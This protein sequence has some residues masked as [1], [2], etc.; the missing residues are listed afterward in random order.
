MIG[1]FSRQELGLLE[2]IA[3]RYLLKHIVFFLKYKQMAR[4]NFNL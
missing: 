3:V 1:G 4:F 2:N